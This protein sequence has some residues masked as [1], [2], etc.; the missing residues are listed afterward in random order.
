M[1]A[2]DAHAGRTGQRH[3]RSPRVASSPPPR[4]QSNLLRVPRGVEV[5][6]KGAGVQ[7]LAADGTGR[8]REPSISECA[9]PSR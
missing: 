9:Y 1:R 8:H 3:C 4:L 7:P 6:P 5:A 2:L